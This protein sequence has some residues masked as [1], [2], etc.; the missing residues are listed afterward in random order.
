MDPLAVAALSERALGPFSGSLL[1]VFLEPR[2]EL[3]LELVLEP[4][5]APE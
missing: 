2:L 3:V 4:L 5:L 1:E